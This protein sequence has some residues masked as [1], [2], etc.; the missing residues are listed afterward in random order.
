MNIK[1]KLTWAFATIACLP[2]ILVAVLVVLNLRDAAK[3]NFL[4]SSGREIRQIDN[5]M[6]T[7]FDG[8]RKSV[9]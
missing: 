3:T 9:V 8:D 2:V 6:K 4:D 1:Q 7:F 5:G